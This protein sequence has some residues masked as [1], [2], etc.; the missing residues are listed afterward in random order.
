MTIFAMTSPPQLA[1]YQF[2]NLLNSLPAVEQVD[3]GAGASGI[4]DV[5]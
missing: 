4:E 1:S 3:E 2:G 5:A